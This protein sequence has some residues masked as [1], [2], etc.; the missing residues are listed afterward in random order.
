MDVRRSRTKNPDRWLATCPDFS[1]PIC[2]ELRELVFR[3][4]PDLTESV[5]TNMLCFSGRKRVCSL[6]GF[7]KKAHFT[8]YRGA[9]LP[10]A[11]GLF[12]NGLENHS[13]RNIELTT[14]DNLDR[15]ALRALLHAA[16]KL[17]AQPD[18]PQPPPN[19]REPFPMPPHLAEALKDNPSAVAFFDTL[20]PTYQREYIVWNTIAKQ[21]ETKDKRLAETIAALSS[22][23]KWAQ[24]KG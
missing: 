23:R 2:E 19:K 5:N 21:Q 14:L 24:R 13:I 6:G 18:L 3:W 17:D 1:R 12:N 4:E 8:F 20:K 9:E 10:D 15:G 16:V 11:A 7:L 22:G